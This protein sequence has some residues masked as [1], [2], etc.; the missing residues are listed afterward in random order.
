MT[1]LSIL[2]KKGQLCG[3]WPSGIGSTLNCPPTMV[4]YN[5]LPLD[6]CGVGERIHGINRLKCQIGHWIGAG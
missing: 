6:K 5:G 2:R 1:T 3:I 4:K